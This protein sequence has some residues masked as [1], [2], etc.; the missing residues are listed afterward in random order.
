MSVSLVRVG[1]RIR[2]L[3]KKEVK[4]VKMASSKL[5]TN[6]GKVYHHQQ[7]YSSHLPASPVH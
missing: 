7:C 5:I 4:M 1:V 3:K 2:P 6:E